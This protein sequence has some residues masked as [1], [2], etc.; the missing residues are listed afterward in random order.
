MTRPFIVLAAILLLLA[1]P[2]GACLPRAARVENGQVSG[3]VSFDVPPGWQVTRN[4]RWVQLRRVVIQPPTRDGSLAVEWIRVSRKNASLP[5]DLVAEAVIGNA[6]REDGEA[7]VFVGKEEVL[8]AD[9]PAV[10]ITGRRR[11][12]PENLDF[13]ALVTRGEGCLVVVWLT[14][15]PGGLSAHSMALERV[16]NTLEMPFDPPP[17]TRFEPF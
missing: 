8:L 4:I 9:R 11:R 10:A 1:L 17:P 5:L 12:G 7:T 16:M 15:P 14:A 3:R 13:T 2:A 6:G